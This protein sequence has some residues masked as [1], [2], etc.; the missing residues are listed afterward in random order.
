[1]ERAGAGLQ[2]SLELGRRLQRATIIGES[3]RYLSM[4]ANNQGQFRDAL[5]LAEQARQVFAAEGDIESEGMALAAR[6]TTLFNLGRLDEAREGFEEVLPLFRRS[7]H[8]YREAVILGNLATIASRQ[9]RLA[10]GEK[11]AK[12]AVDVVREIGDRE[13]AAVNLIVL[14]IIYTSVGRW[15]EAEALLREALEMA[16][17]IGVAGAE[18]SALSQ[19]SV[20]ELEREHPD[21]ALAHAQ[22]AVLA[23]ER[24]SS[25]LDQGHAHLALGY[26]ALLTGDLRAAETAF[27]TAVELF[28]EVEVP[29]LLLEARIGLAGVALADGR[30]P[31]AVA[32]VAEVRGQLDR[33][34]LAGVDRPGAVLRT[35][36]QV[37]AQAGHPNADLVLADAR[38][39]LLESADAIGDE[40]MRAGYLAVPV[41]AAL[42]AAEPVAG[43]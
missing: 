25:P 3:L 36:W 29:A 42:V 26:A 24:V 35:C 23:G 43:G 16:R 12:A 9:A 6:A 41:N 34:M 22:A 18:T 37:L 13:G 30:L 10:N 8:R 5:D 14:A 27:S 19:L 21:E 2:R 28:T 11:W 7:G 1:M 39:F 17:G 33:T 40:Q 32:T 20:L 15:A 31:D 4:L 38:A